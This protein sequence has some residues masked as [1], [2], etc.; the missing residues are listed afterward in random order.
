MIALT[1]LSTGYLTQSA[2]P[3]ERAFRDLRS[4]ALNISN[5]RLLTETGSLAL[6]DRKTTLL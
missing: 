3:L 1:G 2:I 6:L 5:E 4:A